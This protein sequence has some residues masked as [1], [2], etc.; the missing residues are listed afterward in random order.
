MPS[1]NGVVANAVTAQAA[2]SAIW[3]RTAGVTCWSWACCAPSAFDAVMV[4][5]PLLVEPSLDCHWPARHRRRKGLR[6]AGFRSGMPA[7]HEPAHGHGRLP[8]EQLDMVQRR[9]QDQ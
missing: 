3:A 8:G 9:P 6:W 5:S 2:G 7:A 4:G 1:M